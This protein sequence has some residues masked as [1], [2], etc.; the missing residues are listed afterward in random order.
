MGLGMMMM[1]GF[2]I[3]MKVKMTMLING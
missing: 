2:I 1:G 3:M